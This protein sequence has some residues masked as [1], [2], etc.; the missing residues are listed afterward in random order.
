MKL[1]ASK[2]VI[3][4]LSLAIAVAV[5]GSVSLVMGMCGP[6]TDVTDA[7]FCPFVLEIFTL[8]ITAGTT[9]TTYDPTSS[10]SRLQMAAFLSRSVDATL[11]R[12]NR[13]AALRQFSTPTVGAQLGGPMGLGGPLAVESDGADLWVPCQGTSSV[14]RV[15]GSDGR[16]LET[17]T[18]ATNPI[19][20]V[21][22]L[23]QVFVTGS[24]GNSPGRLYRIDPSQAAGSVTTVATNIGDFTEM[25]AFDGTHVWTANFDGSV[26]IVTPSAALPWTV[27]TVTAGFLSPLGIVH[28]GS[29]IWVTDSFP[30]KLLKLDAA[31]AIL[32]TVTVG[33]LPAIPVFDGSAIWVPNQSDNSV[34]VVRAS[35]GA[36]L[37]TLTGNGLNSP[38]WASFD[39]QRVLVTNSALGADSVSLWKAADL[40]AI[41]SFSTGAGSTPV[42]VASD[43]LNFWIALL[44]ADK[45]ARF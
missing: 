29:N 10:V 25:P 13:R 15:R 30:G 21:V 17:W 31:G 33:A 20:I 18:G 7:A 24:F 38:N 4:V 32:Q 42:A 6:F 12:G 2:R 16:L 11:K 39:G 19:G 9:A 8:G 1:L 44:D 23:G 45:L 14:L 27:T 26:S 41:G 22:A 5:G 37:A 40:T 36:V 35:N 28:D 3:G 34:T 43:G